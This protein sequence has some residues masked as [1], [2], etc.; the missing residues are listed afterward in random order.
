[1]TANRTQNT[2]LDQRLILELQIAA[3]GEVTRK[4]SKLGRKDTLEGKLLGFWN[5]SDSLLRCVAFDV[6]VGSAR[7]FL[8]RLAR[9]PVFPRNCPLIDDGG[10]RHISTRSRER[11]RRCDD[12]NRRA[13]LL[14]LIERAG[15]DEA[16]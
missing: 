7:L 10:H 13:E 6:R 14:I 12:L 2:D 15:C 9:V 3:S 16:L 8:T 5:M 1:M 4:Q 11:P